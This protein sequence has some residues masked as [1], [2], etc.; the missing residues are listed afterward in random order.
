MANNHINSCYCYHVWVYNIYITH[1]RTANRLSSFLR[2]CHGI[3]YQVELSTST[4]TISEDGNK[5][6]FEKYDYCV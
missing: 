2:L 5:S 6:M 1:D 4:P 3:M